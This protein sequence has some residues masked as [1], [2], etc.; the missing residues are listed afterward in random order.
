MLALP[1]YVK[2][3]RKNLRKATIHNETLKRAHLS[4]QKKIEELKEENKRLRRENGALKKE[5]GKL[6]K[7][8]GTLQ[9]KI[10][11]LTKTNNRYKIALFDHGNFKK[12]QKKGKRP[13][14][15]QKGH[16]NTN[17]D[18]QRDT[19]TF[20]R[21]RIHT[22][23]C[24]GCGNDL[25]QTNSIKEKIL[26]DIALNTNPLQLILETERQWCG[27]CYK[28]IRAQHPQ[29]LPFTEYGINTLMII[30]YLRF[31]G[32]QSIRTIATTLSN[33]FG[34]QIGKSGIDNLLTQAKEYLQKR[35]D[36]LKQALRDG[37]IMY[38][39]ETGWTVRG[40]SAWMWIMAS[41]DTENKDGAG[42]TVYVAAESRGK[43]IF[44]EMYGNSQATS[45]HD[46]YSSYESITGAEKTAYCW[47]H[48]IRFAY[49][50]T[51]KLP[52]ESTAYKIRERLVDL[53]QTIRSHP[54]WDSNKKKEVMNIEL[55][56]ILVI[57]DI[58]QSVQKIQHR[59][60]TQKEGLIRALLI[61]QDG[62]NNLAEREF[63]GLAISRNISYGSDT[64]TG[65]EKTAVLASLSQTIHR[66][67]TIQFIPTLKSYLQEG[68]KD[69][70]RQFWHVPVFDP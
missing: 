62:T 7:E 21:K 52:P 57:E 1:D 13:K 40:K 45:M 29:T 64:Y 37:D 33:L 32:K 56:T 28:D 18:H 3:L 41:P 68:V 6:E 63:R 26:I 39:D 34:L 55:D 54:E 23:N 9:E 38:N 46:G 20:T 59:V 15:G 70:Y 65:M 30:M 24:G 43:G 47:A 16:A 44:E 60:Q 49:E 22:K 14:G 4:Q 17:K 35:Y 11:K 53:Y 27:N 25:N 19:A 67:K 31:K 69:K 5:K 2:D 36:Q 51:V 10:E 66:D 61:T 8:K 48:V 12:P 50:E 42:I 58:H